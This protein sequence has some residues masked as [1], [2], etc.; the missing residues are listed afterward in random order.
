MPPDPTTTN[1]RAITSKSENPVADQKPHELE[2]SS[3]T[4]ATPP[5]HVRARLRARKRGHLLQFI[6][7]QSHRT[8]AGPRTVVVAVWNSK[9][10]PGHGY[11]VSIVSALADAEAGARSWRRSV[12]EWRQRG[13]SNRRQ[14]R[15]RSARWPMTRE[16]L[17][18][19][20]AHAQARHARA[21]A[22]VE[23]LRRA[24]EALPG[25]RWPGAVDPQQEAAAQAKADAEWRRLM[26]ELSPRLTPPATDGDLT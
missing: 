17:D 19:A 9:P 14:Y 26:T 6:V 8:P 24:H 1:E 15:S 18:S 3:A 11:R 7:E 25:W 2:V 13:Q 23:R 20:L 4:R 21:E 12:D 5:M 16:E 22:Q 10:E